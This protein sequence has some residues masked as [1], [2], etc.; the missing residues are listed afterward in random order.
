MGLAVLPARLKHELE[1]IKECLLGTRNINEYKELEKHR[2][3]FDYL[4]YKYQSIDVNFDEILKFEVGKIFER[5]LIDA[6][7][8]KQDN[9]GLEAF[10]R[11]IDCLSR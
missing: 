11:F 9:R 4:K 7:V 2:E 6:G 10:E 3:W 5:I 8:F 1:L